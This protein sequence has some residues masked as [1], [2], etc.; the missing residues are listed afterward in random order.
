MKTPM[1]DDSDMK[2]VGETLGNLTEPSEET[3]DAA[4]QLWTREKAN[5]NVAKARRAGAILAGIVLS[6]ESFSSIDGISDDDLHVQ[7]FALATFA[8][9]VGFDAFLPNG[10]LSET[11]QD[12]F[13]HTLKIT[14]PEWYDVLS[15]T[16]AISFYYLSIRSARGQSG[17]GIGDTFATLCG[18]PGSK[19]C[20]KKGN[21]LYLSV[22]S[23]IK[24]LTDSLQFAG[25]EL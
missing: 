5:G 24:T 17:A 22:L 4:A 1:Y 15:Q 14:A 6:D 20:I 8:V 21:A 2:V 23:R 18:L 11:A 3:A 16:G 13:E 10:I 25:N 9:E 7:R 19:A 12:M